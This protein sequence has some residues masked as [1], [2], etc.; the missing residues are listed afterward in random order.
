M[1]R[2]AWLQWSIFL[3]GCGMVPACGIG[4]GQTDSTVPLAEVARQRP[5]KKATIV[6]D[7]D[8]LRKLK[9]A[10]G[11]ADAEPAAAAP[12]VAEAN[13]ETDAKASA[14]ASA[15]AASGKG[16]TVK[17]L[18]ENG[19]VEQARQL[20]NGLRKD[21][22]TLLTR[23]EQLRQKVTTENN[24]FLRRLYMNSLSNRDHTLA[25]KQQQIDAVQKA[26]QS[27]ESKQQSN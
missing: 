24:D 21:K 22:E 6:V 18:L 8:F 16:L 9:A 10:H 17:G 1:K 2:K 26:I 20:L 14:E 3:L 27:A 23:Y 4:W 13:S 19:T 7:E 15:K 11:Q 25:T 12:V 5:T